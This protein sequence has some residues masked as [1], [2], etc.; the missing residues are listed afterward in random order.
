MRLHS[1]T[2]NRKRQLR[3]ILFADVAG[4]TRLMSDDEDATH[5]GIS[6]L[7]D[8]F[9]A[10]CKEH[11]GEMLELR[12]DG[13]FA[14]FESAADALRFAESIHKGLETHNTP[15]P[16]KR[17]ILLRIGIHLGDVIADELN[18]Y[19]HHVNIA[20]RIEQLAP[21]GG[22]CLSEAMYQQVRHSVGLGF[23]YLGMQELKNIP[24]RIGIY[25]VLLDGTEPALLPSA[26]PRPEETHLSAFAW[27]ENGPSVVVLPFRNIGL[28]SFE[29]FSN[30]ITEDITTLISRFQDLIVIARGS[31]FRYKDTSEPIS[32]IGAELRARY[33]AE[34]GVLV[35]GK[36][37]R[38]TVQLNDASSDRIIWAE[39][40]DRKL[41]DIFE[42]QDEI[43]EII[44]ATLVT[45][46]ESAERERLTR[47]V[48][49]GLDAYKYLLR[50]QERIFRYTQN[51][52]HEAR[53]LYSSALSRDPHY[54]RALAAISRT[55]N[56]DWRYSWTSHS[57]DALKCALEYALKA[58]DYDQ[59]D[60]RAHAELGYVYLYRKEHNLSIS[61]YE[62]ALQLNPNDP[63]IISD[64]ADALAHSGKAE[65]GLELMGKAMR[66]NPYYPD[67]YLWH[68][69]GIFYKLKEHHKAIE[70]LNCA[71]SPAEGSRMLAANYA[72]LGKMAEAR[73]HA[74]K[75]MERHPNFSISRWQ[76]IL[77]NKDQATTDH[78]IEGLRKAGLV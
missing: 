27:D 11:S 10:G 12:G 45:Q 46:I 41:E 72:Q 13:M 50:G 61:A 55:H 60:A 51:D 63:D 36:R 77:P 1:K 23:E 14:L 33:V 66:L 28:P 78:Y 26:R 62:R 6:M 16:Q 21:P 29:Y 57:E 58:A 22:I 38:V 19:G 56:L 35:A 67:Q 73:W 4:Y 34:G 74:A 53:K 37:C 30:G 65:A 31:A 2:S 39:K 25:R 17:R 20:A 48:P 8:H 3:A 15:L 9:D 54:A 44:V 52:N 59:T 75:L 47:Q 42:I 70:A 32:R 64:M 71:T 40:Y 7:A 68:L 5:A 43:S 24:E 18:S 69:A 76:E 49:S